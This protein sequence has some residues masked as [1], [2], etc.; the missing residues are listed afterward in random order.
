MLQY[1]FSVLSMLLK[2]G[3]FSLVMC[4]NCIEHTLNVISI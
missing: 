3:K 1:F 2:T 4:L